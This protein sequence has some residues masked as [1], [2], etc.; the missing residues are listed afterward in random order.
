M[1]ARTQMLVGVLVS[2]TLLLGGCASGDS[3]SSANA[4]EGW[5]TPDNWTMPTTELPDPADFVTGVDNKYWP[6]SVGS[7]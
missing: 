7:R 3:T 2:A 4:P 1:R 5:D 6:L